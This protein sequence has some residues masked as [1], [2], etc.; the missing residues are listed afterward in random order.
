MLTFQFVPDIGA[1]GVVHLVDRGVI[2]HVKLDLVDDGVIGEIDEKDF[3]WRI[4]KNELGVPG[5]SH[6][7]IFNAI[8][9]GLVVDANANPHRMYLGGVMQIDDGFPD[10]FVVWNVEVNAVVGAQTGGA[11]V[12]LHDF[13]E[14]FANL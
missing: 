10:D 4:S 11:P 8:G 7:C 6:E 9:R 14:A 3:R 1:N 2:A 5:C 13:G 12:D